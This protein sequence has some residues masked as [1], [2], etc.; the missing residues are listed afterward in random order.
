M[1][2]DVEARLIGDGAVEIA[3]LT[4]DS[5][6]AAPGP[7]RTTPEAPE[8][9]EQ[10]AAFRDEGMQAVAMEVSSH[11]L[12]QHRVDGTWFAVAVFTNLSQDHLD[13]HKDMEEYF[14]AKARLFEPERS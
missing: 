8:L 14:R 5:R 9:Q 4:H 2:V 11:A 7:S 13:Y 3:T 6:A 12:D 10:L 1:L